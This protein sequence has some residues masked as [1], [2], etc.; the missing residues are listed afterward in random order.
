MDMNIDTDDLDFNASIDDVLKQADDGGYGDLDLEDDPE[1]PDEPKGDEREYRQYRAGGGDIDDPEPQ[2]SRIDYEQERQEKINEARTLHD[3]WK[4][5]HDRREQALS[6]AQEEYRRVMRRKA[7]GE[8]L[9]DDDEINAQ[10]KVL[11]ARYE[12]N[13]AKDGFDQARRYYEQESSQPRLAPAA[14]AWLDANSSRYGRDEKFTREAQKHMSA[15]R[16]EGMDDTHQNF[17]RKLDER[18]R[19]PQKMGNPNNRQPSAAGVTRTGGPKPTAEGQTKIPPGE[20]KFMRDIGFDPSNKRV[21]QEWLKNSR[22][23]R[24]QIN[25]KRGQR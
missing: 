14:Q 1:I 18:M 17:Y 10:Q 12:V 11:D 19:K 6:A 16:S 20:Q 8:E 3:Q 21:A 22:R 13:K 4:A 2:P 9:G 23:A 25:T 5:E 15:L 7:E 24:E